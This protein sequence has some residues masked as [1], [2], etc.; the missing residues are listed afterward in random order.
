MDSQVFQFF[1]HHD[2]DGYPNIY[3]LRNE[4]G[5]P[6]DAAVTPTATYIVG[7][8]SLADHNI[9]QDAID[10]VTDDY[11]IILVRTGIYTGEGNRNIDFRGKAITVRSEMGPK[12]C[13]IDCQYL[14][15]GFKL[16]FGTSIS[17]K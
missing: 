15:R 16:R 7:K 6:I 11:S 4:D 10:A 13:I 14:G 17:E 8:G 9:I 2:G 5:N 1:T 3:E 12:N